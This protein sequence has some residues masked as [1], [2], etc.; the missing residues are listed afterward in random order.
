MT[1]ISVHGMKNKRS[2]NDEKG[3]ALKV[4]AGSNDKVEWTVIRWGSRAMTKE[5]SASSDIRG[6]TIRGSYV[7][8]TNKC[9][10]E[11]NKKR[12]SVV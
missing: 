1:K 6:A 11:D 7:R 5:F 8:A 9:R 4:R 2:D 12:S 10:T 3:V